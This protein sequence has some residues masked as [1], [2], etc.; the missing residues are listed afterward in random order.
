MTAAAEYPN[1]RTDPSANRK[2]AP[3]RCRLQK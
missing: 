1:N 3:P 2:F